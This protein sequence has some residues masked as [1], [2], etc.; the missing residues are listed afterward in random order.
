MART[1]ANKEIGNI[2]YDPVICDINSTELMDLVLKYY[3]QISVKYCKMI[4]L[5]MVY[6]S[7]SVEG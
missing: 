3:D 6:I 1:V 4:P 2:R 7:V 5:K